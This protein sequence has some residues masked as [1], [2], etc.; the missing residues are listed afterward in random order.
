[1]GQHA[2]ST[3]RQALCAS[4]SIIL[5][6]MW[7]AILATLCA[8]SASAQSPDKIINQAVKAITGGKGEKAL[9]E[10]RSWQ[11]KGTITNL[12]DGSSG[13]Y[14]AAAAKPD[15]YVREFDQRGLELSM[16][17]N[18][19]SAWTRDSHDGL[20]TLTGEASRDFQTEAR[21][22]NAR[23]LDYKK[24]RSKLSFG[25]QTTINGKPANTVVLTTI[26]NVKIKLYFDAASG[27]LVRE[28]TPAGEITRVLDYSDFRPVGN[29]MEPH[30][31]ICAEGDERYEIKLDQVVHSPQIDRAA[32]EFPKTS[33]EALPDIPALLNEVGKNEDEIDRLLEKYTYTETITKRQFDPKGQMKVKESET[34]ELTFYKGARIRRLV[35]KNGKPLTPK[36]D[37]DA[38]KA[39][40][41]RIREIEK[42]EAEKERKEREAAQKAARS[43]EG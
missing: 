42:R 3:T 40:E 23:W 11:V 29:L 30:A 7:A 36:E 13:A 39:V 41:K 4:N 35:A 33:G 22:R 32:F 19:K 38:Q 6:T 5:A 12:K 34:F 2:S 21:Y 20:R 24:E 8:A 16:G 1:M 18:G 43:A 26:K 27:L 31:I 14:R 25:G 37:A 9:R 28:E 10:I 17:Y 15:L